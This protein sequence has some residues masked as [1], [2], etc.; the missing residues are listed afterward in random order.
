[1]YR[2]Y[3]TESTGLQVQVIKIL[4][5]NSIQSVH[6][7][8][9]KFSK[10]VCIIFQSNYTCTA[11]VFSLLQTGE[12]FNVVEFSVTQDVAVIPSTW[13]KGRDEAVWP[14]Y[15]ST[16]RINNAVVSKELPKSDWKKYSIKIMYESGKYTHIWNFFCQHQFCFKQ[17]PTAHFLKFH[18]IILILRKCFSQ[19]YVYYWL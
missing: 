6:H 18:I 1:M 17:I 19:Y 9:S 8:Y 15:L 16:T 3:S 5:N 10:F 11:F 14:N 13:L 7:Y 2:Y 12:M 4:Y